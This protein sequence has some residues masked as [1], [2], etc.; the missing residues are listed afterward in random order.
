MS[1]PLTLRLSRD[2][3]GPVSYEHREVLG[4]SPMQGGGA[5]GETSI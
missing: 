5:F 4:V 3:M 2:Y 1:S